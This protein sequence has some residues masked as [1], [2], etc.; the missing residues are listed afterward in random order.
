MSPLRHPIHP[1]PVRLAHWLNL[2]AMTGMFMSGWEI[3]NASRYSIF[4]FPAPLRWVAGS[5]A[6]LAGIW[7]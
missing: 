6:L 7:R 3:Y 5:A 2:L 1:W 4:A